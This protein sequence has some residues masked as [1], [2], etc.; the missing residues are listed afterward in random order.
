MKNKILYLLFALALSLSSCEQGQENNGRKD[1]KTLTFKVSICQYNDKGTKVASDDK[2][3]WKNGD[4][5]YVAVDGDRNNLCALTYN[6]EDWI[7]SKLSVKAD[8]SSKG[9]LNAVYA[10]KLKYGQGSV[11]TQGDILYTNKGTYETK[12]NIVFITLNMNV[13]P[14]AKIKIKGIPTGFYI[15][16]LKEFSSV[17]IGNMTWNKTYNAEK[18]YMESNGKDET[19][20]YGLFDNSNGDFTI[21]L[22]N[23]KGAYYEKT[24]GSKNVSAGDYIIINGPQ[25]A[26]DWKSFIPLQGIKKNRDVMVVLNGKVSAK[27]LFSLIPKNATNHEVSY[28]SDNTS[29][30]SVDADGNI[31]GNSLGDAVITV[32]TKDGGYSCNINIKV[33]DITQYI[34]AEIKKTGIYISTTIYYKRTCTIKNI[35]D[36]DIFVKSLNNIDVNKTVPANSSLDISFYNYYDVTPEMKITFTYDDTVYSIIGKWVI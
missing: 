26:Q 23:S 27:E 12:N 24:F 15:E 28:S 9:R 13:R 3:T 30:A 8:F 19:A 25:N 29:V 32:T 11:S 4:Q 7:V 14:V 34:S 16:G 10:E 36:C 35:S 33:I 1:M 20:Y 17:D 21:K 31:F 5:I 6:G 18:Q 2:K 22:L